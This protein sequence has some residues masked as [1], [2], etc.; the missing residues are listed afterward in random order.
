MGELRL[1]YAM[2]EVHREFGTGGSVR[3]PASPAGLFDGGVRPFKCSEFHGRSSYLPVD[4]LD[5]DITAYFE[6]VHAGGRGPA[7]APGYIYNSNPFISLDRAIWH[8][9]YVSNN[10]GWASAANRQLWLYGPKTRKN[11]ATEMSLDPS[12]GKG[13]LLPWVL[14]SWGTVDHDVRL[15]YYVCRKGSRLVEYR[16]CWAD[17]YSQGGRQYFSHQTGVLPPPGEGEIFIP[18][19][20]TYQG[21][22]SVSGRIFNSPRQIVNITRDGWDGSYKLFGVYLTY[23]GLQP[24]TAYTFEFVAT[25]QFTGRNGTV[26]TDGSGNIISAFIGRMATRHVSSWECGNNDHPGCQGVSYA[27]VLRGPGL[28]NGNWGFNSSLSAS[29]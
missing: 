6:G 20:H 5:F 4:S 23:A 12:Q 11:W 15:G 18:C 8:P 22:N 28:P 16:Q 10:T 1:P 26:W 25:Y 7:S 29:T 2:S 24:N 27:I 17:T 13:T 19:I 14:K 3:N 21:E 9:S